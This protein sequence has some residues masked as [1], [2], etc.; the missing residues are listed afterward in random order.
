MLVWNFIET[1]EVTFEKW[2]IIGGRVRCGERLT[3]QVAVGLGR[4]P[5]VPER[6]RRPPGVVVVGDGGGCAEEKEIS[7]KQAAEKRTGRPQLPHHDVPNTAAQ[8]PDDGNPSHSRKSARAFLIHD[9]SHALSLDCRPPPSRWQPVRRQAHT[10]RPGPRAC[11]Q[12]LTGTQS[13]RR[14]PVTISEPAFDALRPSRVP[15]CCGPAPTAPL[16]LFARAI[17]GL[18]L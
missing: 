4:C 3:L 8:Q 2:I 15:R 13:S 16:T 9:P 14:L 17:R 18:L 12:R 10:P 1:S 7:T 5:P 11:K 6:R